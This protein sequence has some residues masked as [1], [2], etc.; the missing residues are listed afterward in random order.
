MFE[1]NLRYA[2]LDCKIFLWVLPLFS[3]ILLQCFAKKKKKM[4]AKRETGYPSMEICSLLHYVNIQ[5]L[6]QNWCSLSLDLRP[7]KGWTKTTATASRTCEQ[8]SL[9][10]RQQ[11]KNEVHSI[12]Y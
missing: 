5:G 9:A 12:T 6:S 1:K 8:R 10:A 11:T 3:G 2:L 4:F 7:Y